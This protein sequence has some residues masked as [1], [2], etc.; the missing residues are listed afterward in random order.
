VPLDN[1]AD[2]NVL[3]QLS[4]RSLYLINY[5]MS[6]QQLAI[7]FLISKTKSVKTPLL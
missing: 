4:R 6:Q 2:W 1:F 3:G 7:A 5:K